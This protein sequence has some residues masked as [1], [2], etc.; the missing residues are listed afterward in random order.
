MHMVSKECVHVLEQPQPALEPS[1]LPAKGKQQCVR[2]VLCLHCI[3][4]VP[5][6]SALGNMI[7]SVGACLIRCDKTRT[8]SKCERVK[9]FTNS[10]TSSLYTG[11]SF[12]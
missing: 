7:S 8:K 10:L 2:A 6:V 12:L 3:A 5:S 4:Q 1:C 9:I 11:M